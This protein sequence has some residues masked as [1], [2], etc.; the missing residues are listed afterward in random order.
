MIQFRGKNQVAGND[1]RHEVKAHYPRETD[2]VSLAGETKQ[3]VST[4]LSSIQ[5]Q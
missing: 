1:G 3:G 5:C 2:S 4:V